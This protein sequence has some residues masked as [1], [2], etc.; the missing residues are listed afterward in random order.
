MYPMSGDSLSDFVA[1]TASELG[2]PGVAVGV[3]ADGRETWACHGV[4]SVAN[5]LPIDRD[6]LFV[7]GSVSK[8]FAATV[9]MRL[10]VEGRVELEAPV[11]RYVPELRLRDER[12]AETIT[13]LQLLNH[14]SGLGWRMDVDTGDGDD[15]LA[16]YVARMA[17]QDLA[18]APGARA[19]YSQ[20][21]YNLA[22]RVVEKVTGQTYERAV[23][24][25]LFAPLE[26]AHSFFALDDVVSRRFAVGHNRGEDGALAVARQWKDTRA[27]NPGGGAASSAA[28][29]LRW[30]RFHLGDGRAAGG[31]RVLP[32]EALRRMT[33]PTVALE[34]SS[35]GD[36]VGIGWFLREVGGVHT[37]GHSGSANGQFADLLTVPA[38]DF[39]VIALSN[40]G[41][42]GGLAFNH[43]TVRFALEHYLGVVDRDP[44]PLPYDAARVAEVVGA[45]ENEIMTITFATDGE[46]LTVAV[47]IKPE[48]RAGTDR[49]L[50]ADLPPAGAGLLPGD[51]D[52]YIVTGGGMKG[53][54]GRFSRDEHGAIAGVDAAGRTLRRRA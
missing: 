33:R 24:S 11:R 17:D 41:P 43:A 21:G 36:A 6:T 7:L 46:A 28:D 45:Y 40:E 3:W 38:R 34:A 9:L 13:V 32:E 12:A 54:R 53:Q 1:A 26:M 29:Q 27:N 23:S 22:G 44:E 37:V 39:A 8:T 15:A 4:T 50:P 47:A 19:S 18:A 30:A 31:V 52:E 51:G 5:P 49:E 14:T 35:L 25:L 20:V 42:D 2:V 10:A 16:A 48:V